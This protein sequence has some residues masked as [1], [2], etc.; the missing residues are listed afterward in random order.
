MS[1]HEHTPEEEKE[2]TVADLEVQDGQTEDVRG[3]ASDLLS[4][5]V[6]LNFKK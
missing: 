2:E 3:G 5:S 6:S 4:E 1:D